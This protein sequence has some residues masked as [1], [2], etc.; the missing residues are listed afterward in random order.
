MNPLLPEEYCIPDAEAHAFGGR[1]YLYGSMDI[2]GH[3]DYCSDRYH[4][5]STDDM[6]HW[7]DHGIS[8][9][10]EGELLYA[11]DCMAADGRYYLYYCTN[12]FEERVAASERPEGPFTDIGIIGR[13]CDS[14]DPAVFADEDGRCY[15]YWGQF[16]LRGAQLAA[17]RVSLLPE[18]LNTS[19]IDEYAHGFHEG[20]SVRR[21]GD[22]Y[23]LVYTDISRG[24]ATCLSYAMS[25]SPL[26][27]FEKQGVIVDNIGC[28]PCTWNNHGSIGE[29]DG[30]WYVF[31]HRSSRNSHVSRRVCAE[32]ITFDENGRIR[33]VCMTTQGPEPP[34]PAGREVEGYRFCYGSGTACAD[35][36]QDGGRLACC[37]R[38]GDWAA[39]RY[40]DL[41]A[42]RY[43]LEVCFDPPAAPFTAAFSCGSFIGEYLLGRVT[44][45][46]EHTAFNLPVDFPEAMPPTGRTLYITAE[47]GE[48]TLAFRSLCFQAISE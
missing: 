27:P 31:Y 39:Y 32:P 4:V 21:R 19:L 12:R 9:R 18:T 36:P 15:F 48:G 13:A 23:Y 26:G 41:P 7:T 44:V 10:R 46:A 17:D 8:C 29:F 43:T 16:Q 5:F 37:L 34:I 25:R 40:F 11:P 35:V 45:D 20:A 2:P 38:R 33:E 30:R 22:W 6:V 47:A 1:L 42:R 24:K 28:D 14:I 3:N